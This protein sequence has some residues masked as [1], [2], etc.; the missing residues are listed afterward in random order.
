MYFEVILNLELILDSLL[1]LKVEGSACLILKVLYE[2]TSYTLMF[3][4]FKNC[5]ILF[6]TK[7]YSAFII[8]KTLP[9]NCIT[10]DSLILK[11]I[12]VSVLKHIF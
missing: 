5:D 11:D 2:K 6:H 9:L 8:V 12:Q 4:H 10:W 7:L 3:V 1:K